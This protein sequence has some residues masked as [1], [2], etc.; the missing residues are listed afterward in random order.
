[1]SQLHPSQEEIRSWGVSL[2]NLLKHKAGIHH[3]KQHMQAQV[4][5]ENIDFWK[6]CEEYKKMKEGKKA[7]QRAHQIYNEFVS[8][9]ATRQV[10]S[11]PITPLHSELK[12]YC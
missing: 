7:Q 3:L 2:E 1:M 11:V 4:C 9:N 12:I 5:D 8:E 6:E 10:R